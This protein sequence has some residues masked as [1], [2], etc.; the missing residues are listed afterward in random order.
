MCKIIA[1][2]DT[3]K[4]NLKK[5]VNNIGNTLLKTESD[6]FGYAVKGKLGVFGEKCT[7]KHFR[8][9]IDTRNAVTLP[10][11]KQQYSRFGQPSELT[12]PGIFHGRTSTNA[13][14]LINTHPMQRPDATGMWHLVHN[15]VV[16]DHGADYSKLT[17]ND[18]EDVLARLMLGIQ[19]VERDLSGY[20]AFACIDSMGRL[21]VARDSYAT[22]YMAWSEVYN[23][24]IIATTESLLTKLNKML[25]AKLGPVD[26]I[27]NDVYMVFDGNE[28]M[29]HQDIKPRGFTVTESRHSQAS[30]GR[31]LGGGG[32]F[33]SRSG[34]DLTG[35]HSRMDA[36][37][38]NARTEAVSEAD[39]QTGADRQTEWDDAIDSLAAAQDR[40]LKSESAET[41]YYA[42]RRE[43]DN[44]DA[45]YTIL[46]ADDNVIKLYEFYKLDHINQELCTII[47]PDGT[48]IELDEYDRGQGLKHG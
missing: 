30:L 12:G 27:E 19:D 43:I 24:Y 36:E 5:H 8:S 10:I 29:H 20:Y 41:E 33:Y 4:L 1:F 21:H 37:S 6:G 46:D 44:M 38:P 34:A 32:E 14:G 28:L 2:T 7:V 9:R 47:R 11:V 16:T 42:Y 17:D 25:D 22:L 48:V 31:A 35:A 15:G 45:A 26:E 23:T 40:D 39:W 18:S 3:T 13:D